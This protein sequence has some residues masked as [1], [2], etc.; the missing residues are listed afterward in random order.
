MPHLAWGIP[1]PLSPRA[2]RCTDSGCAYEK[3]GFGKCPY[4][5][6]VEAHGEAAEVPRD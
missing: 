4:G 1:V 2:A 5:E 6:C 3:D